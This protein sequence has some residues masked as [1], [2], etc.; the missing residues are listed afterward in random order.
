MNFIVLT[1]LSN[2]QANHKESTMRWQLGRRSENVEDR[3]GRRVSSPVVVGGG[4]LGVLLL[5]AIVMLLG[6]DPTVLLQSGSQSDPSAPR[7]PQEDEL[8]DFVSVV[9]ADTE[10]T[11]NELFQQMGGTYEEPTLVLFTD[12]V[13][14]ACGFAQ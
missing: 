4:G 5:A 1:Y 2:P 6:G 14:S 11:W 12:A 9:L 13:D 10:D 3:R 7:S 8:A